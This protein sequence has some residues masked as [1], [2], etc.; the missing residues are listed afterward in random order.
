M[1]N[2]NQGVDS[3]TFAAVVVGVVGKLAPAHLDDLA[4]YDVGLKSR[5]MRESPDTGGICWRLRDGTTLI[6]FNSYL[7]R[8]NW[9]DTILHEIAHALV[10]DSEDLHG[11]EWRRMALELGAVPSPCY[12]GNIGEPRWSFACTNPRC[13]ETNVL[14]AFDGP[15]HEPTMDDLIDAGCDGCWEV[16]DVGGWPEFRYIPGELTIPEGDY[17]RMKITVRGG[18]YD[19]AL[20]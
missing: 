3:D 11:E 7:A 14:P 4:T 20:V 5:L 12:V 2:D 17:G 8:A 6:E 16:P 19:V 18:V 1:D 10:K 15:D 9:E 13:G